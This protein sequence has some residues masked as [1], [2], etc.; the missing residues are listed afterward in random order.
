M[1]EPVE[2]DVSVCTYTSHL[3]KCMLLCF[4]LKK[5]AGFTTVQVVKEGITVVV[6]EVQTNHLRFLLLLKT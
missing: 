6:H 2:E 4:C 5:P 1:A 3:L